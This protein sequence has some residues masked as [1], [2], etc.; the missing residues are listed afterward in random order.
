MRTVAATLVGLTLCLVGCQDKKPGESNETMTLDQVPAKVRQSLNTES[1]TPV[2]S[3]NRHEYKGN[4]VYSTVGTTTGKS[5][6]I[7]VDEEGRLLRRAA[8]PTAQ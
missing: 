2:Q 3:I 8:R 6:D 1:D 5:Y 4:V 7:E